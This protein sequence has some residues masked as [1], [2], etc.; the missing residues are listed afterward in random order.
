MKFALR[1]TKSGKTLATFA[2]VDDAGSTRGT[3][4]VPTSAEQ[5]LIRHWAGPKDTTAPQQGS[6]ANMAAR[7]KRLPLAQAKQ[8]ILRSG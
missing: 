3:I 4:S 8:A 6:A 5:D 7:V 2:V 1:K